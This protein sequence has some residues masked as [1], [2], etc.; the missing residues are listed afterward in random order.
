VVKTPAPIAEQ[1]TADEATE[2]RGFQKS[3]ALYQS[4]ATEAWATRWYY[5]PNP[6]YIT[7]F[8]YVADPIMFLI[9]TGSLPATMV[10]EPPFRK[11]EIDPKTHH[12]VRR[13]TAVIYA[14]DVLPE[15]FTAMPPNPP[16]LPESKANPDPDPLSAPQ[17]PVAPMIAPLPE[18]R[19]P[20][21][22]PPPATKAFKMTPAAKS[23][24]AT[25]RPA[26]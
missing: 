16:A 5:D 2:L 15:T 14:G 18:E 23:A 26:K 7:P 25:T 1:P 10:V 12:L 6:D 20:L 4:G 22:L 8:N 13:S 9:Q 24:A 17:K 11:W 3:V 19:P 21:I